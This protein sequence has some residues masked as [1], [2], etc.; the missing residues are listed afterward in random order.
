MDDT[1]ATTK[2]FESF[3]YEWNRFDAINDEDEAFWQRYFADVDLE[4]INNTTALDAGCGKARYSKFT[5]RHVKHLT[6]LDGSAAVQAAQR[7]LRDTPN[8]DVVKADLRSAPFPK[9]TFGFISCLGVLHHL[10][11]P[12]LGFDALTELLAPDGTL[13]L[14]LYS[15]PESDT[16]LRAR[17][18]RAATALRR[19]TLR[20]PHPLLRFLAAPL[21]AVLY[22]TLV[23][24][25]HLFKGLPLQTYRGRPLRSL[26]LDT[27][28][29]LSAPLEHRYVWRELEPWFTQADMTVEAVREEAGLYIVAKKK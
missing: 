4:A 15:R 21:A 12:K 10:A 28:D 2:T 6:A 9:H 27:F 11:D 13:L 14:Y 23:L 1:E 26:W 29:R 19:F 25:G 8:A 18:L 17:G 16:D 3:G 24:P 22:L 7:N 20:L 5:A